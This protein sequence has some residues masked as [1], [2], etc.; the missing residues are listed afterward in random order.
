M[1]GLNMEKCYMFNIYI[2][3]IIFIVLSIIVGIF[4]LVVE[5]KMI[6]CVRERN[7]FLF[8]IRKNSKFFSK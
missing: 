8:I 5:I 1:C 6:N 7:M 2:C 3:Y 4:L